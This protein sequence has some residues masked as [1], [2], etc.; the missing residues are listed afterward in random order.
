MYVTILPS[1]VAI[2]IAV[3]VMKYFSFMSWPHV[4]TCLTLNDLCVYES[5]IEIKIK[6]NFYF[7]TSLKAFI[8]PFEA[9]QR[10]VKIKKI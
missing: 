7:H 6:L 1:L 9:P 8:K 4:T 10:S 3:M 2:G 5:C